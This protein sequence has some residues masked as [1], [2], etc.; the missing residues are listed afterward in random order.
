MFLGATAGARADFA[1]AYSQQAMNNIDVS[2][3]TGG[4][5]TLVPVTTTSNTQSNAAF[6]SGMS[7]TDPLDA[8]QEFVGTPAKPPENTF[9]Q[10]AT[11]AANPPATGSQPLTPGADF[12]R[13]DVQITSLGNLYKAAGASVNNVAETYLTS[14]ANP[15]GSGA[16]TWSV[17]TSFTVAGLTGGATTGLQIS[18]NFVNALFSSATGIG[19]AQ[20][21]FK[22]DITLRDNT[23]AIIYEVQPPEL[24]HNVS[25][26]SPFQSASGSSTI[27]SGSGLLKSGIQ[28]TL[29]FSGGEEAFAQVVPEPGSFVLMGLGLATIGS[30]GYARRR[31]INRAA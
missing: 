31:A 1:Y 3:T 12:S 19:A 21:N 26:N 14:L 6:L 2:T 17:S 9:A 27:S 16:G 10:F 30:L 24:N 18:Y 20:S 23:G 11:F 29:T 8:P 4:T 25:S 15:V 5:V 22:V 13:G 7:A 28:Y